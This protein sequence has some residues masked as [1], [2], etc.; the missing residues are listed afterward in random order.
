MNTYFANLKDLG[1]AWVRFDIDW[2]AIQS[3]DASTY[4]WTGTDRVVNTAKTYGIQALGII[5]YAPTWAESSSCPTGK[6]CPPTDPAAFAAFAKT[7]VTRYKDSIS[8]W[9]IWNEENIPGFWY[10][11]ANVQQ[12]STLLKQAYTAIK[13]VE[14]Q[15]TVLSGGLAAAADSGGS[16]S[17]VTF[18][19]GLYSAGTRSSFDA[20]ALHP[21]SYPV[22]VN[23]VASWNSWQQ[24]YQ[25]R[26]I[27]ESNGDTAKK[28][29]VTEYGAPTGGPGTARIVDQ[30]SFT[31]DSDYMTE[32]AQNTMLQLAVAAYNANKTWM[33]PFFW[34][35]LK[36]NGSNTST[37]ENFFGLIRYDGSLKPAYTTFKTLIAQQ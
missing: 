35:S 36:D 29:W 27:M 34:Y 4:D 1:V 30:L 28:I 5:T 2:S 19:N 11:S 3:K 20:L 8:T 33:G 6:Y 15:S 24:M 17:P 37:P 18:V 31:Y 12:Y 16:I 7:V 13:S 32:D 14:P 23:Y 25:V 21:Y 9:E 26:Q 22:S 10:P